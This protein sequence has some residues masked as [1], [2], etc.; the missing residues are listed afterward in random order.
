MLAAPHLILKL[1]DKRSERSYSLLLASDYE[2][3]GW[4]ETIAG[5]QSKSEL[6]ITKCYYLLICIHA[7][8]QLMS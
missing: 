3:I 1:K 7:I 8:I 2:R 6:C 4:K 5:L